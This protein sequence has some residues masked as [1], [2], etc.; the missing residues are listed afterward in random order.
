MSSTKHRDRVTSVA[1][2]IVAVTRT[3][4]R[5]RS[6]I[7]RAASADRS[8]P[9]VPGVGAGDAGVTGDPAGQTVTASLW[10]QVARDRSESEAWRARYWQSH[11]VTA[12]AI[13]RRI[14]GD[15]MQGWVAYTKHRHIV[16]PVG[17]ALSLG[18][19]AGSLERELLHLDVCASIDAFDVAPDAI[20]V[21]RAAAD[22]AGFGHRVHYEVRDLNGLRLDQSY[23]AVFV[24]QSLHHIEELEHVL[25]EAANALK[26]DGWFVMNEYVGPDRFQWSDTVEGLMN[27]LLGV[28]PAEL[29]LLPDG[30][31]KGA[32]VRNSVEAVIAVDPSEAIRSAA[33]MDLVT[34]RFE[35][36]ER[37][38]FGGTLLQF[39]LSEI[40]MNFDPGNPTHVSLLELL[41]E[42]ERVLVDHHVI[43][44]DFVY[45]VAR[46]RASP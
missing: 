4:A 40:A 8:A 38:D 29:K 27:H 31:I 7:E 21:A 39:V 20:E 30:S 35:I 25:S 45:V 13:N 19:G 26:P 6:D 5:D 22:A 46:A 10:G 44:S 37:I 32:I 43:G 12:A 11:P 28:L 36:V 34:Q 15:P 1:R 16:Q 3:R 9:D 23:D 2:R 14:S 41:V 24:A 42:Y 17:R 33:I 18:C